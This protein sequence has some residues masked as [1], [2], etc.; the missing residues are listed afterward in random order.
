MLIFLVG[1]V[2]SASQDRTI[3]VWRAQDGTLCRFEIK[4][5]IVIVYFVLLFNSLIN[6]A[7]QNK[8]QSHVAYLHA[9]YMLKFMGRWKCGKR[10]VLEM[11]PHLPTYCFQDAARPR[12][13]GQRVVP[14][15]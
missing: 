13:L 12:P 5:D 6:K 9:C 14:Q 3:K 2:Y 11:F 8:S 10:S 1:L 4:I 15:Y 7:G